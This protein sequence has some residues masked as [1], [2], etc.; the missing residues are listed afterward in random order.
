MTPHAYVEGAVHVT[1]ATRGMVWIGAQYH[2]GV[3]SDVI[4]VMLFRSLVY[5]AVALP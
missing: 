3:H 4:Q 5:S 2:I 1:Y